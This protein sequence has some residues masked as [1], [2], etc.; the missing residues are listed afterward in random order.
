MSC[1]AVALVTSNPLF[2]AA[3]TNL[4]SAILPVL[5]EYA[6]LLELMLATVLAYEFTNQVDLMIDPLSKV[7]DVLLDD[8]EVTVRITIGVHSLVHVCRRLMDAVAAV[9]QSLAE[10]RCLHS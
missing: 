4:T 2:L 1:L 9:M 7:S 5:F 6:L 8:K 3:L 10:L